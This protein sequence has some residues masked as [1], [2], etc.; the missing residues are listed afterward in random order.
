MVLF[1]VTLDDWKLFLKARGRN[2]DTLDGFAESYELNKR[3]IEEATIAHCKK[4]GI[5]LIRFHHAYGDPYIQAD[6]L[7]RLLAAELTI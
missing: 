4:H 2:W 3:Y 6:K 5:K 7:Q 1:D